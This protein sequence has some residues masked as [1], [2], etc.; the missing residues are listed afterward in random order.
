M[1]C[2]NRASFEAGGSALR[3]AESVSQSCAFRAEARTFSRRFPGSSVS[4][5]HDAVAPPRVDPPAERVEVSKL[6]D[7]VALSRTDPPAQRVEVRLTSSV[8]LRAGQRPVDKPRRSSD[9]KRSARN[10]R[11]T[12]NRTEHSGRTW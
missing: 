11:P 12:P 6:R 8:R 4:K 9:S 1:S 7:V 5:P 3:A 2:R 10:I